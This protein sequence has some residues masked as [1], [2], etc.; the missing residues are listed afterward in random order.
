MPINEKS[1]IIEALEQEALNIYNIIGDLENNKIS[2]DDI[3]G[4]YMDIVKENE[5]MDCPKKVIVCSACQTTLK[6]YHLYF[7]AIKCTDCDNIITIEQ[8]EKESEME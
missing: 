2:I 5:V 3:P 6:L 4:C 8:I 1:K 7:S